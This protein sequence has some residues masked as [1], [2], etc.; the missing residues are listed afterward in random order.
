M[1]W[2]DDGDVIGC[3]YVAVYVDVDERDG[4]VTLTL[5]SS[6]AQGVPQP[7]DWTVQVTQLR[8]CHPN[9]AP[10]NC[11][12]YFTEPQGIVE[13]FNYIPRN[14][15]FPATPGYFV[16]TLYSNIILYRSEYKIQVPSSNI[17]WVL[18]V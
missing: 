4:P 18:T 7:Q 10:R 5:M 16:N 8:K 1:E 6:G 3:W 9:L 13:S 2:L 11:L 12:Q 17:D 14:I 15:T